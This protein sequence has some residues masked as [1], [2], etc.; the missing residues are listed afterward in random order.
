[1]QCPQ[2]GVENEAGLEKCSA[3][4]ADLTPAPEAAPIAIEGAETQ[5]ASGGEG[6]EA[7]VPAPAEE[8][9]AP[10]APGAAPP[11]AAVASPAAPSKRKVW[12]VVGA[13]LAIVLVGGALV[14]TAN[15]T[16]QARKKAD[17]AMSTAEDAV[18]Q[19]ALAAEPGTPD[20]PIADEAKKEFAAA[21]AAYKQG[22]L[23]SAGPYEQA[24]QRAVNAWTKA[25]G[26]LEGLREEFEAANSAA[27]QNQTRTAL[28]GYLALY[29]DH[30]RSGLAKAGMTAAE[31]MLLKVGDTSAGS[32]WAYWSDDVLLDMLADYL[33]AQPEGAKSEKIVQKATTTLLDVA[34]RELSDDKSAAST[35]M[36]WYKAMKTKHSVKGSLASRFVNL[37]VDSSDA[38]YA[39][40]IG[41][42]VGRLQQPADMSK[43]FPL[44]SKSA[45]ALATC[46]NVAVRP[47]SKRTSGNTVTRLVTTA[48]VNKVGKYAKL[49]AKYNSQ[50]S[51][52]LSKLGS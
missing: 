13:A 34:K 33:E 30:P 9:P 36:S 28:D 15:S 24:R 32:G 16:A 3:C 44:L 43:V 10:A 17:T 20:E 51:S 46:K 52:L 14:A 26:L 40:K 7:G 18:E 50:V 5:A 37:P 1:M 8:P 22:W 6:A 38:Q 4:G 41:K 29:R 21:T 25:D 12:L 48:Q 45:S 42:L 19:A 39:S 2:C 23:L 11:A 47:S 49:A 35:S 31:T 27:D